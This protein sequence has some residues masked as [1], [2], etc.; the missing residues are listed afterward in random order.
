MK[1]LQHSIADSGIWSV[2]SDSACP[3]VAVTSH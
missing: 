3:Q 1:T 2:Y